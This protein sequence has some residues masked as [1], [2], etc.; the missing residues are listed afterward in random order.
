[1]NIGEVASI[2]LVDGAAEVKLRIHDGEEVPTEAT[3]VIRPKTLFGEKFV[4]IDPGPAEATGPYLDDG[5]RIE[6]TQG[7]FELE[8]VLA[9]TYPLLKA[10][11]PAELMTVLGEMA[12]AGDGLGETINRTIV[13][14]SELAANFAGNADETRQF[15][16]SFA[17]VSDELAASADDLLGIADAGNQI[18]P[19][20]N[21][22]E[23]DI[24][25]LLQQTGRLS[26][27]VADLLE[28]NRPFVDAALVDGS[29]SLQVLYD[30]RSQ[31]IPLVTGL[32]TYLQTLSSVIRIEIG[33]GTL[34]AAVKA[35]MGGDLCGVLPCPGT[36]PSEPTAAPAPPPLLPTLPT[37]PPLLPEVPLDVPLDLGT[38]DTGDD[39]GLGGLLG[40]V[41]GG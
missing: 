37:L 7:G 41:F 29:R 34:M 18:L 25:D 19:T 22:R 27:D 4:D 6:D 38:G 3:A 11:D 20:L 13:N 16:E 17:E 24:V 5:D 32:R 30:Q 2:R 10:V 21:D 26:N 9:D 39:G 36:E 23:G 35:I 33:D 40:R 31:V 1:V 28:A 15:L 12:D 8:K 14:S